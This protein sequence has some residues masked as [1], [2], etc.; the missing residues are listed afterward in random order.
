MASKRPGFY[1]YHGDWLRDT[2]LR[3]CSRGTRATWIDM[4]CF[5]HENGAVGELAGTVE[6]LAR[7]CG[8]GLD[9]LRIVLAELSETGTAS[10]ACHGNVT[11]GHT[12]VTIINRRMAREAQ[13]RKSNRERKKKSRDEASTA[14]VAPDVTT[15]SR[16]SHTALSSSLSSSSSQV[17]KNKTPETLFDNASPK[18]KAKRK[19]TPAVA[20]DNRFSEFWEPAYYKVDRLGAEAEWAKAIK[21]TSPDNI[22]KPW[23]RQNEIW[24]DERKD[25]K[26]IPHPRKWLHRQRWTDEIVESGEAGDGEDPINKLVFGN[27]TVE[28]LQGEHRG[29]FGRVRGSQ[30][31]D[32]FI[33][34]KNL[35]VHF[36]KVKV[37]EKQE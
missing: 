3:K 8:L 9:E 15:K 14:A 2:A 18:P 7:V 4:L 25:K 34:E 33:G 12:H 11:D 21:H 32:L 37:V 36:E 17:S 22:L 13:T 23:K 19:K 20:E 35:R 24:R 28:I 30:G 1:F 26:Y 5:M 31:S 16:D 10:V 6:Q 29:E 27:V